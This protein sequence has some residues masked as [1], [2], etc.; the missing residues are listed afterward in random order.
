MDF[1]SKSYSMSIKLNHVKSVELKIYNKGQIVLP[2]AL[3]K[4]LD[5]KK[6]SYVRVF[7]YDG[8][9]CLLPPPSGRSA[10]KLVGI[11]PHQPSLTKEL[12][13]TRKRDF[14]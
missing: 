7:E 4:K 12:P 3:R 9:I 1:V 10:K 8:M 2:M 13:K 14:A 11:L 6:G 5:L